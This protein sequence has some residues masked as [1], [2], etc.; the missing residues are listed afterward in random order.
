MT[1]STTNQQ[2]RASRR[3]DF[4]LLWTGQSLSLLGDY[5]AALAL[6]LLALEV[7]GASAAQ[8]AL[9]PFALFV[10]YLVLGLP[11]G[12]VV[13]RL[14][15]RSTMLVCEAVQA[16]TFGAIA[17]LALLGALTLPLLLALAALSGCA[18]V[19]FQVAYTS[20]LPELL[21]TEDELG[22]GNARV[23]LSE[24]VSRTL[25]PIV[26]GPV[27]AVLGAVAAVCANAVSFVASF[28]T[29]LAIRPGAPRVEPRRREPGWLVRDVREGMAFVFRHDRLEPVITCGVVYV[30]FLT[31][32]ESSL[33]L[34]CRNV[35]ALD[36]TRIG[37]IVGVAGAGFP[38]GNLLSSRLA[39]RFGVARTLAVSAAVAVCG[40]VLT[41]IAGAFG[42]VPALIVAGVIHGVGEGVFGPT[43]LTLRQT[44]TPDA[45]LGRVNS[46]QRFLV[47][48]AGPLGSVFAVACI[49][50]W[51]LSTTLWIGGLGTMLC[52]PMLLRRGVLHDLRPRG[53]RTAV[54]TEPT[55]LATQVEL[56]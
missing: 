55:A 50:G 6:P 56:T 53:E 30:C 51:G 35:L 23:F 8:A 26:A 49:R 43:A 38:V 1:P 14:P 10:P 11:A 7:V 15:R 4:R 25:G 41:P 24:S 20:Y 22:V 5:F 16:A 12:A 46:V 18:L 42:S 54:C 47:W 27:I 17:V 28:A 48:G 31:M 33:I 44:A 9:L 13:D 2:G 36:S 45:L 40:H 19:F 3:R 21:T 34:Y 52:L 37:L 29:L 39:P 32:I